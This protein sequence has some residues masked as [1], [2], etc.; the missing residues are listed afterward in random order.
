MLAM[1]RLLRCLVHAL[2]AVSLLVCVANVVLWV[3]SLRTTDMVIFTAGPA[4]CQL[5]SQDSTIYWEINT[6]CRPFSRRPTFSSGPAGHT[7]PK[8]M[9]DWRKLGFGWHTGVI[10]YMEMPPQLQSR[11]VRVPDW[12]LVLLTAAGPVGGMWRRYHRRRRIQR[13]IRLGLCLTCGYDLRAHFS[14]QR[15]PEC[16]TVVPDGLVRRPMK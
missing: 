11:T 9:F 5:C 8:S 2:S 10:N 7:Q 1:R 3:R 4:F 14:G 16:G 15:C 12:F 13:R 6:D